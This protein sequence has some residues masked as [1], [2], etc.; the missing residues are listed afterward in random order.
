MD[1]NEKK[2]FL[3]NLPATKLLEEGNIKILLVHGSPRRNNE[4]ILPTTP[5]N[6]VEEMVKDCDADIILCGHTHIPCG[7]QTTS[8]KTVVNVGSVGRPFTE[9]PK[10]CY[11]II[12]INNG[13][14][15]LEH[16]FVKYD[17]QKASKIL[18]Q[19]GFEGAEKLSQVLINPTERHF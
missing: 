15:S 17:N 4:D 2:D 3:K 13:E 5:L 10:S 9:E 18:S 11:L 14:F 7:F 6:D 12:E 19:R 8:R 1:K 16:K